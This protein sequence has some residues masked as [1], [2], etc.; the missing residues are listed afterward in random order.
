MCV[1]KIIHLNNRSKL[2]AFPVY[3]KS[4]SVVVY[5]RSF[6]ICIFNEIS[7]RSDNE[8]VFFSIFLAPSIFYFKNSG[9]TGLKVVVPI[10][11]ERS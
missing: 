8:Y 2:S 11:N 5:N 3:K 10:P 7:Q 6:V 4:N 9:E 1:Q